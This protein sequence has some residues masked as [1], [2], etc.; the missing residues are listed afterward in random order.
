[1]KISQLSA[2]V[3]ALLFATTTFAQTDTVFTTLSQENGTLQ[4]QQFMTEHDR[5]FGA[6]TPAK[7]MFKVDVGKTASNLLN[8]PG[9]SIGAEAK[10]GEA[11]SLD[12]NYQYAQPID[13][14]KYLRAFVTPKNRFSTTI[15][16]YYDMK[17]RIAA[18]KSAANFSGNYIGFESALSTD[19]L[20][21]DPYPRFDFTAKF[22]MQRRLLRFGYFDLSYGLG[23]RY[24][25]DKVYA[26]SV[27][28][29]SM[30][31]QTAIGLAL[32]TPRR[33]NT[34]VG[35]AC[36]VLK[37]FEENR[38]MFKID[39]YNL[40]KVNEISN[41]STSLSISPSF[42][43]EQ[44]IGPS[45]FSFEISVSGDGNAYVSKNPFEAAARVK[46]NGVSGTGMAELRWYLLQKRRILQ[47]KSGNNLSGAF[48]GLHAA[49]TAGKNRIW[50]AENDFTGNFNST[51]VRGVLGLQHRILNHGFVQF[52]IG[53]GPRWGTGFS[54][55]NNEIIEDLKFGP[56]LELYTEFKAG[57]AF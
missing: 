14:P 27:W 36:D 7:W 31:P 55:F 25:P 54:V 49:Y 30:Q 18:G 4:P 12:V 56:Q 1:M 16:W 2:T 33:N 26:R 48:L 52:K 15:R 47:G 53:A 43:Y 45:P 20:S 57:L 44:K 32:F 46:S 17:K 21:N 37:C 6:M 38:R 19:E 3:M 51:S 40:M 28:T 23:A 11:V 41:R 5:A 22:G 9:F 50:Y 13:A 39:L 35:S 34:P 10:L 8:K 24:V 29:F 42:A